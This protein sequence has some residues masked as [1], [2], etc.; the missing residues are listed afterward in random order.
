MNEIEQK[1]SEINTAG[2]NPLDHGG[3]SGTGED[4]S[5]AILATLL[6]IKDVISQQT[7]QPQASLSD[8]LAEKN[9]L[10]TKAEACQLLGVSSRT[11]TTLCAKDSI[12]YVKVGGRPK[13]SRRALDRYIR[14]GG[15]VRSRPGRR[16]SL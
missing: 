14:E 16:K 6:E 11:M 4:I 15:S 9:D 2:A 8:N 5:R 10:I 3:N 13:F 1:V 12:P 7:T